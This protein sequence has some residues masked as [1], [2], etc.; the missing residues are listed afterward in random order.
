MSKGMDVEQLKAVLNTNAGY[1]V[2][3]SIV[4][5]LGYGELLQADPA[6]VANHNMAVQL[7]NMMMYADE[8]P[9]L[10]MLAEIHHEKNGVKNGRTC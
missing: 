10:R 8:K 2:L 3:K 7:V 9:T 6:L 1:E 4:R 5:A